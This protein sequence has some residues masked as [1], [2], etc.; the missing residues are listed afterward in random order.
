MANANLQSP[1]EE[2]QIKRDL[3]KAQRA[4]ALL[5][6]RPSGQ[7]SL[8]QPKAEMAK[9]TPRQMPA[10]KGERPG[11]KEYK[12]QLESRR[13]TAAKRSTQGGAKGGAKGAAA[14]AISI[15]GKKITGQILQ[16]SWLNLIDTFGATILYINFHF[17]GKYIAGS[18]AFCEFGEEWN[19]IGG[20]PGSEIGGAE[21]VTKKASSAAKW[22][23]IILLFLIDFFLILLAFFVII[24]LVSPVLLAIGVLDW[25]KSKVGL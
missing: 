13:K 11:E 10:L 24:I 3:L 16:F 12:R 4:S 19:P 22:A 15:I 7:E 17:F 5:A 9:Q 8:T 1:Q 18:N 14:Q 25:V 21:M 20:M 6:Q 2:E 23:E